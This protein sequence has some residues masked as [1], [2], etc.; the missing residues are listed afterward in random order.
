[1][2]DLQTDSKQRKCQ[3]G[4]KASKNNIGEYK[5]IY[6]RNR[7]K[8]VLKSAEKEMRNETKEEKFRLKLHLN[9]FIFK[10]IINVKANL[11]H[12]NRQKEFRK[13]KLR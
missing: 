12:M 6:L 8:P 5:K 1:M 11:K 4:I 13:Q 9:S 10:L 7:R 3:A 2:I